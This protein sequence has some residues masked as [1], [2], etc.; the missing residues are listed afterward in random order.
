MDDALA[1]LRQQTV[2]CA[3]LVGR[4]QRPHVQTDRRMQVEEEDPVRI[5]ANLV[6]HAVAVGGGLVGPEERRQALGLTAGA[7]EGL[8]EVVLRDLPGARRDRRAAGVA[9]VGHL[10]GA[11]AIDVDGAGAHGGRHE[12]LQ[13]EDARAGRRLHVDVPPQ[14]RR[15]ADR[16]GDEQAEVR[17]RRGRAGSAD[18]ALAPRKLKRH[19]DGGQ[20]IGQGGASGRLGSGHGGGAGC[21]DGRGPADVLGPDQVAGAVD[22]A[23]VADGHGLGGLN[24]PLYRE[25]RA[26]LVSH[27]HRRSLLVCWA[28]AVSRGRGNQWPRMPLTKASTSSSDTVPFC[29]RPAPAGQR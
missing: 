20:S 10:A 24:E 23:Q 19:L 15:G 14:R 8:G 21:G 11:V 9:G 17:C 28:G 13:L 5:D 16:Q 6:G 18:G 12:L 22:L 2:G 4:N 25:D 3:V 1:R 7:Q 26:V 27:C 29:C